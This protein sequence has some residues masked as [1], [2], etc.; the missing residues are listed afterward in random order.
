[1]KNLVTMKMK[2]RIT[3][4]VILL[5]SSSPLLS[6]TELESLRALCAEQEMQIRQLEEKVAQLTDSP[7]PARNTTAPAPTPEAPEA[8]E[9]PA[10]QPSSEDTYTVKPGDSIERIARKN[11]T[12]AAVLYK[13]NGLKTTS[14]IHPGQKI[15]LPK[16]TAQAD[17]AQPSQP[18]PPSPPTSSQTHAVVSGDNFYRIS[19]K[20]KVSVD[21]LIAANPDVNYRALKIGQKIKIPSAASNVAKAPTPPPV[22]TP[23]PSLAPGPTVPVLNDPTPVQDESGANDKLIKITKEITYSEFAKIHNTTT[24]RLDQL[25]AL[26]LD[27]TTVLAQGSELYVPAQP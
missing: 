10:P 15:K 27:P 5:C 2:I 23:A 1:M 9:A 21:Q 7:P 24:S 12:S 25:N 13:L 4:L 18:S 22:P 17:N 6:A 11:G 8:P 19:Q 20:Y 16:S 14:L 26:E 3:S